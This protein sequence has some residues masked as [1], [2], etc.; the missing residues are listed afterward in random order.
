[1]Q[2]T[3]EFEYLSRAPKFDLIFLISSVIH[4]Q[5]CPFGRAITDNPKGDLD[6]SGGA[7]DPSTSTVIVGNELYPAGTQE[8]Y[9][10]MTDSRSNFLTQTAHEYTE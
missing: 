6:S 2:P 10:A 1:M 7:L 9:P 5:V 4:P 3:G 8:E